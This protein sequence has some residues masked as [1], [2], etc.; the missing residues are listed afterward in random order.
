[1]EMG[2]KG[3]MAQLHDVIWGRQVR[4][5]IVNCKKSGIRCGIAIFVSAL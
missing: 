2:T 1:M 3:V 5:I 4:A